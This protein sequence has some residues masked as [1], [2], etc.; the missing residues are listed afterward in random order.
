MIP[1]RPE[2]ILHKSYLDRL[3]IEIIDN[4]LLSQHLAFKGGTCATMLGFLDRF[5]VDLDFD[6][7][8]KSQAKALRREFRKLFK[9][10]GV[11]VAK[12]HD[13]IMFFQVKY[14]TTTSGVRNTLKV[15]A[16]DIPANANEYS[17]QYFK[18]ID[19]LMKSQTIETMFAN[20]LVALTD[21]YVKHQAIAGRD[22]YDT[23]HFF[24]HG[25]R[26]KGA[27][28]QERTGLDPKEYITNLIAFITKHVTQT[29]INEDLNTLLSGDQFQQIR[30]VLIPETIAF[31]D[32]EQKNQ[33]HLV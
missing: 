8:D 30:K 6:L 11:T 24:V 17:V 33:M 9:Q 5:S 23:H 16:H 32:N 10:I 26:Y 27:V 4:P 7:L 2:D 14:P 20:K 3:L 21:R 1:L 15:S 18:E 31:L 29:V 19:R 22:I 13:A 25:Y 12:E 28:I